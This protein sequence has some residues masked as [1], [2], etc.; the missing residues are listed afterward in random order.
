MGL[1]EEAILAS[2][3]VY[4]RAISDY[5]KSATYS[6]RADAYSL[7]GE[8]DTA[9]KFY[10]K[11]LELTYYQINLYLPLTECYKEV[12]TFSKD[13][14]RTMLTRMESDVKK[15]TSAGYVTKAVEED[16]KKSYLFPLNTVIGESISNDVYWAMHNAADKGNSV[17][18]CFISLVVLSETKNLHFQHSSGIFQTEIHRNFAENVDLSV[19]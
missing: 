11:A 15:Y 13:E 14:W 4:S 7:M 5:D 8:V 6:M 9:L 10:N 18:I 19:N 17:M 3:I 12:G 2:E 1:P 16:L